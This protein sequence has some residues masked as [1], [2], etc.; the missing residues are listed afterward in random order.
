MVSIRK[1]RI[2]VLVS[3]RI[4]YWSNYSIRFKISNI[5]TSVQ[6]TAVTY[7]DGTALGINS[8]V[9]PRYNATAAALSK[10]FL[11]YL[12][13]QTTHNQLYN[14]RFEFVTV[15]GNISSVIHTG[16]ICIITCKLTQVTRAFSIDV[17][18]TACDVI[19]WASLVMIAKSF[20]LERNFNTN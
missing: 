15:M 9:L 20:P 17:L 11:M 8:K 2:F 7:H 19:I 5:R 14:T 16:K 13:R 18:T 6:T 12:Q 1:F 10:C 4:E 3:N